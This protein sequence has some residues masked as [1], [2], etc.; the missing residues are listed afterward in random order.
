MRKYLQVVSNNGRNVTVAVICLI[1]DLISSWIAFWDF[2]LGVLKENN[3]KLSIKFISL[4]LYWIWV[5]RF[6]KAHEAPHWSSRCNVTSCFSYCRFIGPKFWYELPFHGVL[7]LQN[8]SQMLIIVHAS[9]PTPR[10][11][12]QCWNTV[13]C[14]GRQGRGY[15]KYAIHNVKEL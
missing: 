13:V 2:S 5:L 11:A 6:T 3:T 8:V 10:W 1:T 9:V 14:M 7:S 4:L 15:A 12:S